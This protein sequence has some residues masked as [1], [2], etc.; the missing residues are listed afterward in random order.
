MGEGGNLLFF[1][2]LIIPYYL[3]EPKACNHCDAG[4]NILADRELRMQ[5]LLNEMYA[6]GIG[7][8]IVFCVNFGTQNAT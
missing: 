5:D 2:L 8:G 1:F 4:G 7:L 3:M 6:L